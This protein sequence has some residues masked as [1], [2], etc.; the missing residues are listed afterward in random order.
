MVVLVDISLIIG[1]VEDLFIF[2][3]WPKIMTLNKSQLPFPHQTL[4][5][6]FNHGCDSHLELFQQLLDWV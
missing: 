1:N 3:F 5:D 4:F 2:F 6:K